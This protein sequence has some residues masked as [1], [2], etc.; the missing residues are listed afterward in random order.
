MNSLH[1]LFDEID[2][3]LTVIVSNSIICFFLNSFFPFTLS[4]A[5]NL[6]PI[7]MFCFYDCF[8]S[9]LK[10]S[11]SKIRWFR[12]KKR[13]IFLFYSKE[14]PMYKCQYGAHGFLLFQCEQINGNKEMQK[15]E[16]VPSCWVIGNFQ[17][18]LCYY[19][20]LRQLYVSCSTSHFYRVLK[21]YSIRCRLIYFP[22]KEFWYLYFKLVLIT[23][24]IFLRHFKIN[25]TRK[26]KKNKTFKT[27]TTPKW[28]AFNSLESQLEQLNKTIWQTMQSIN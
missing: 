18:L 3:Y 13:S 20:Q 7:E 22:I 4:M 24:K 25:R 26:L 6:I 17:K 5:M 10:S 28:L 2:V 21:I 12:R 16:M 1:F 23:F 15:I 9:M 19:D 11:K 27:I 8:Y 14:M